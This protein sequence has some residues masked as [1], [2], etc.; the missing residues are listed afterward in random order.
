MPPEEWLYHTV[1]KIEEDSD[2]LSLENLGEIPEEEEKNED[3]EQEK[4]EDK[5]TEEEESEDSKDEETDEEDD[6]EEEERIRQRE[7]DQ[8]AS[9]NYDGF[10]E[11]EV[12]LLKKMSN[13]SFDYVVKRI[14]ER[15]ELSERVAELNKQMEEK[16]LPQSY[17]ENPNAYL[18][19]PE[20]QQ[21]EKNI[22]GASQ[23]LAYYQQ[24]LIKIRNGE[25]YQDLEADVNG[26][27]IPI[28]KAASAEGE[29]EIQNKI[30]RANYQLTK[31][32]DTI[33]SLKSNHEVAFRRQKTQ[34]NEFFRQ[35]FPEFADEEEA[36][37]NSE[38]VQVMDALK[39]TRQENNPLG[40]FLAAMQARLTRVEKENAKLRASSS[41]K[42]KQEEQRR[43]GAPSTRRIAKGKKA[44]NSD[45]VDIGDLEEKMGAPIIPI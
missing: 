40:K 30:L 34:Y 32:Q 4:E 38:Y 36:K 45:I 8:K 6:E 37:K 27:L 16:G 35:A 20:Y 42:V 22:N 28:G 2:D 13:P 33:E 19:D 9:R 31:A 18:L 3:E 23:L 10:T 12:S 7:S 5:E 25:N 43:R 15:N 14:K 21:A 41:K 24:Q 26:N 39:K 1:K 11:D 29:L 17:Y 44:K